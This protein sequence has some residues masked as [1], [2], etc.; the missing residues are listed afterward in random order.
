MTP[1]LQNSCSRATRESCSAQPRTPSP[2]LMPYLTL[3]TAWRLLIARVWAGGS[4]QVG[5]FDL[6]EFFGSVSTGWPRLDGSVL[7]SATETTTGLVYKVV[8]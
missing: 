2:A 6:A 5:P 4:G 8:C 1:L 3:T 7:Q